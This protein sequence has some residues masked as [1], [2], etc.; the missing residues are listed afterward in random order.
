MLKNPNFPGLRPGPD[1]G[2]YWESLHCSPRSHR[3]DSLRRCPL[4]NSP[5]PVL[6]LSI[7]LR[8][9]ESQGQTHYKV[10]HR[11]YDY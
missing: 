6:G 9:Y 3:G 4:P 11:K 8:F 10:V 7:R 1:W 2:A 5:T